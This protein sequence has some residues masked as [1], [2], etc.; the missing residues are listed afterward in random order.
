VGVWNSRRPTNRGALGMRRGRGRGRFCKRKS[1]ILMWYTVHIP[2][3]C[4]KMDSH[5]YVWQMGRNWKKIKEK[6]LM[7]QLYCKI[8]LFHN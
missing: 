1:H 7:V 6:L 5:T 4:G 3:S 8:G 2:P